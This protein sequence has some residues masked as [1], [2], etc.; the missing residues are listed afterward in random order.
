MRGIRILP[1]VLICLGLLGLS[2]IAVSA[3]L[4]R[5]KM[6]A[7]ILKAL[8][9]F[10][11][12]GLAIGIVKDGAAVY[13]KGFG[14]K[15]VNGREPVDEN[16]IFGIGSASKTFN[17][18]LAAVLVQADKIKWDDKVVRHMH[19]FQLYDAWV[20]QE[21]T[22]RD[23][24]SHRTGVGEADNFGLLFIGSKFDRDDVVAKARRLPALIGFRTGWFYSNMM[25]IAAGQLLA[26]VTGRSWD[27]GIRDRI[28]APLGMNS[29]S[30]SIRAFAPGDNLATPHWYEDGLPTPI[31]WGNMDT[32]GPAGAINSSAADL[33]KWLQVHLNG[34]TL[35][36][37]TLWSPDIQQEMFSPHSLLVNIPIGWE[38]PFST[39]GLGWF[40]YEYRGQKVVWHGG[41]CDGMSCVIGMMPEKKM[42]VVILQN[43]FP[44]R[45]EYDLMLRIMDMES[46]LPET[47]WRSLG[48]AQPISMTLQKYTPGPDDKPINQTAF[49]KYLGFY[50]S[51]LFGECEIRL[52]G[53][54]AVL[55]F[56]AF[57]SA[58]L[59][60]R[61]DNAFVADFGKGASG[62]FGLIL[63]GRVWEEVKFSL[64]EDGAVKGMDVDRFGV[65]IKK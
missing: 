31:P 59:R 48:E 61:A 7:D 65:F 45:F 35:A 6:E 55:R 25:F 15:T 41:N 4:P 1:G 29:S 50:S 58:L 36:G 51:D 49:E 43:T 42:G 13:V 46:G 44:T 34:G 40:I 16:T 56:K 63:G 10:R 27:D 23:L 8:V 60:A 39:Y 38:T 20:T 11:V 18:G 9:D 22:L 12:P 64:D 5:Q 33:V 53:D 17:A 14:V 32:A 47:E 57:P 3:E 2:S 30:T 28:F 52:E 24:L 54:K 21:T 62:M 26:G 19:N 37:H